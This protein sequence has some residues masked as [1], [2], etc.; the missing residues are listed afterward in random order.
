MVPEIFCLK[1]PVTNGIPLLIEPLSAHF[2]SILVPHYGQ[3][4]SQAHPFPTFS[5]HL[6]LYEK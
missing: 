1:T 3:A 4:F 2:L 6:A 5:H